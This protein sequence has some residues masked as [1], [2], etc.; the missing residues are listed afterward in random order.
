MQLSQKPGLGEAY[1]NLALKNYRKAVEL[2]PAIWG[3]KEIIE[4]IGSK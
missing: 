2:D 3:A 1:L 4:K